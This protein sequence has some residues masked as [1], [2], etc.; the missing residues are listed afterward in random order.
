[1][2][3]F[4]T[5]NSLSSYWMHFIFPFKL[6]WGQCSVPQHTQFHSFQESPLSTQ[7][8]HIIHT[9]IVMF[10][11]FI[12]FSKHLSV[13]TAWKQC[14]FSSRSSGTDFLGVKVEVNIVNEVH[15]LQSSLLLIVHCDNHLFKHRQY[16]SVGV[17]FDYK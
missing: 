6:V 4:L 11:I 15:C 12:N 8:F 7:S 16:F 5:Y 17:M 10:L 9:Y 13:H 14:C 2:Q 3:K 1:M